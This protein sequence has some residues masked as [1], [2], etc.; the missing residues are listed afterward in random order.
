MGTEE[1]D[2]RVLGSQRLGTSIDAPKQL[3]LP[4][5][6][7]QRTAVDGCMHNDGR[8]ELE[9]ISL[10]QAI[11]GMKPVKTIPQ[12]TARQEF[13]I[14]PISRQQRDVKLDNEQNK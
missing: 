3:H 13:M 8:S 5:G 2:Y 4:N 12:F 14:L 9:G 11:I 1:S 7:M 6:E 10:L